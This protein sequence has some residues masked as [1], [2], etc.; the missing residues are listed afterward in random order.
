M[1]DLRLPKL[2]QAGTVDQAVQLIRERVIKGA[3]APGTQLRIAVLAEQLGTSHGSIRE[4]IRVLAGEGLVEHRHNK[5]AVARAFSSG[6]SLDVYAA[7]EAI[8]TWAVGRI[9]EEAAK[10]DF[11]EVSKALESMRTAE[12]DSGVIDADMAFHHAIVRLAGNDRLS[13]FHGTL[14][15]ESEMLLRTYKPFP[16]PSFYAIHSEILDAL[17]AGDSA[18]ADFLRNHFRST[19]QLIHSKQANS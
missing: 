11:S 19:S 3:I 10:F 16:Q 5:G 12:S 17:E 18:S 13:E 2:E 4:A 15:A 14:I 1:T 9:V 6:D 7:R 8:E